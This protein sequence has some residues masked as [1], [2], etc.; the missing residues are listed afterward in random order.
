M[1]DL[2]RLLSHLWDELLSGDSDR[3]RQAFAG[4]EL[5]EQ[6]AVLAHLHEMAEGE[7]WQEGQREAARAA[8]KALNH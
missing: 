1:R 5:K 2:E 7:G 6:Q 8:L 3:V 4:L